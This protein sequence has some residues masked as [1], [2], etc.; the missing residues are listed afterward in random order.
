MPDTAA[1]ALSDAQAV[2]DRLRQALGAEQVLTDAA[3]L[4]LHSQDVFRRGETCLAV[5]RPGSAGETAEAVRIAAEAGLAV[6]PRGGG[7]SY[8]DGY[9]ATRTGSVQ[10]DTSRLDRILEIDEEGMTVTAEAGVT[11]KELHEAL[12]A[13]GL[14]TPYWGPMS[15]IRAT[16]GGALSQGSIFFGSAQHGAVGD[17]VLSITVALSDGTVVSTGTG[18]SRHVATPFFRHHGPDLTGLFTGD[19]GVFGVKL[20]ATFRLLKAAPA[21]RYL[22]FG[23]DDYAGLSQALAA[24]AREGVCSEIAAFDPYLAQLRLRRAS[25]MT[26]VNVAVGVIRNSGSIFKGVAEAAKMAL[27]GRRFMDGVE[28][29]LH[30]TLDGLTEAALEPAVALVRG[31]ALKTGR[32]IENT[33]A[34]AMRGMPFPPPNSMLGPGGERWV[35]VHGIVP[36]SKMKESMAACERVFQEEADLCARH[37]IEHG[38]LMTTIGTHAFLIEPCLY[39]PDARAEIHE[40]FME[41]DYVRRLP[42]LT[43]TPENSR[44]VEHLKFRLAQALSEVGGTHFQLGKFY[45]YQQSLEPDYARLMGEIK[46]LLDPRGAMNPG[47][48]GF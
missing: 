48:L 39:W 38:Y 16:V 24:I 11:W 36:M 35:P 12:S 15:G 44:A 32:E 34:K 28:F 18:A 19:C 26:D 41:E 40:A 45:P 20:R 1:P 46:R 42:V 23:F 5:L 37:G 29:S 47:A 25:L 4:A 30:C 13:R 31:H 10:I 33:I 17:S 8:T 7:M 3:T 2:L 27:A 14:R 22:S 6:V 43:A 9:L 21:Q